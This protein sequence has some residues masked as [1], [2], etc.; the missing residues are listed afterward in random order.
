MLAVGLPDELFL[1]L[2]E[3]CLYAIRAH[4]IGGRY[5]F[6][7]VLLHLTDESILVS[8]YP[9]ECLDRDL[10][11]EVFF[12]GA[13]GAVQGGMAGFK[14]ADASP[15]DAFAAMVVPVDTPVELAALATEDHLGEAIVA[16]V[17]AL[18]PIRP[19]VNLSAPHKLGLHLHEDVFWD[20]RLMIVFHVVLRQ[21]TIVSYTLLGEKVGGHGF[22]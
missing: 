10:L 19:G 8:E 16:R 11:Q 17:D 7:N 15:Y 2:V 13:A 14:A 3:S 21:S 12:D 4:R 9:V 22:L 18:L 5:C 20:D 6:C 1:Q